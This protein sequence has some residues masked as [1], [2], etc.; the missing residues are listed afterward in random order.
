[1]LHVPLDAAGLGLL[2]DAVPTVKPP[3]IA[4]V[5]VSKAAIRLKVNIGRSP[6]FSDNEA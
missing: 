2:L 4:R 3:R 5:P 1:M 6:P